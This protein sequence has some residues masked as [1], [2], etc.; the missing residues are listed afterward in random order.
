MFDIRWI[1]DNP[2]D[3]DAGQV[4]RGAAAQSARLI[5]LDKARRACQTGLQE[6]RAKRNELS[7][8]IGAIKSRGGDA[9]SIMAE[10]GGLKGRIQDAEEQ[11]RRLSAELEALLESL[12]NMP[13]PEVPEGEDEASA[14]ELRRYGA[15]PTF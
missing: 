11:E 10:V 7:K 12:P 13:A 1:R 5:E 8:Q 4:K 6:A 3:F 2:D 9:A 15:P 14:V